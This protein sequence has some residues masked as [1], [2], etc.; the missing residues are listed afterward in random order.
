MIKK[1][2]KKYL[3]N[4]IEL[5]K[6]FLVDRVVTVPDDVVEV[7]VELLLRDEAYSVA[8]DVD[9]KHNIVGMITLANTFDEIGKQKILFL[10][11]L[12]VKVEAR[13]KKV[14]SRLIKYCQKQKADLVGVAVVTSEMYTAGVFFQKLGFLEADP[15]TETLLIDALKKLPTK[16]GD[17][18]P[19]TYLTYRNH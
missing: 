17:E 8:L 15:A 19:L 9:K 6:L 18:G 1:A 2:D 11:N 5:M 16:R 13:N 14:A 10:E 12:F 4:V 3:Q 7:T